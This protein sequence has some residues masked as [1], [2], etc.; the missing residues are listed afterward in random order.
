[1]SYGT[2]TKHLMEKD[3][4]INLLNSKVV[5]LQNQ[6]YNLLTFMINEEYNRLGSFDLTSERLSMFEDIRKGVFKDD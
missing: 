1:M 5:I 3:E 2:L 4:Q 6:M